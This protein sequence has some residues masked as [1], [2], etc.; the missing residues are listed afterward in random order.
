MEVDE[1]V[2]VCVR[3]AVHKSVFACVRPFTRAQ[4]LRG[5]R[6]RLMIGGDNS[7]SILKKE[8]SVIVWTAGGRE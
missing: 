3:V 1:E 2:H 6:Q 8:G 7:L 4:S 5:G